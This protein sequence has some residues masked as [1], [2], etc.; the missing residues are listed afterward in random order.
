MQG[1][2]PPEIDS[3]Y[4]LLYYNI[5]IAFAHF[6]DQANLEGTVDWVFDERGPVGHEAVLWYDHIK[7]NV[8]DLVRKRLGSTPIFRHDTDVLP[9]KA[10]DIYA[11][12]VRRHLDKE[13]PLAIKHNDNLDSLLSLYGVNSIIEADHMQDFVWHN[14]L[15]SGLMLKSNACHLLPPREI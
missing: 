6:M 11:W 12:Q 5:I 13:Q 14:Q 7:A 4:F 10:A 3:P 2:V 1:R 8:D 9:L 15:G